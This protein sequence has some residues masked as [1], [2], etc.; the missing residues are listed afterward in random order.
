MSDE[1]VGW[2]REQ[3]CAGLD[4]GGDLFDAML[5]VDD[6]KAEKEVVGF[7]DTAAHL[8]MVIYTISEA[9]L[10]KAENKAA[11][12]ENAQKSAE[13]HAE[14]CCTE[15]AGPRARHK[16][17]FAPLLPTLAAVCCSSLLCAPSQIAG[18]RRWPHG[19]ACEL[20]R[21]PRKHH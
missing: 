3:V 2:L 9:E 14:V 4:V 13:D 6:A 1:R 21:L 5:S 8:G 11:A 15:N 18:E 20:R 7:L 10:T 12:S 16:T 19:H 17:V